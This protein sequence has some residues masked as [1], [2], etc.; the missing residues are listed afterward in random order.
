MRAWLALGLLAAAP[1]AW[2]GDTMRCGDRIV[3]TEALAA[4]VLAACGTP[5]YRDRWRVAPHRVVEEELWYYNFGARQFVRVLNFRNGQLVSIESD[6]YGFDAPPAGDCAPTD[7][8]RGLSAFRLL[9][10]CGDPVTRE[11]FD[12]L[13]PLRHDDWSGGAWRPVHRERWVYDFGADTRMRIVT[14][15]NGRVADVEL[16]ERGGGRYRE[17]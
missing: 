14:L 1:L 11:T 15:R 7:V 8:V 9:Y 2:G 5:D 17:R 6:G 12:E 10:R 13:R 4:E 3:S 16:G